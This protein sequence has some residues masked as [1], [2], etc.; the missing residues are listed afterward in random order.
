MCVGGGF[1]FRENFLNRLKEEDSSK[2][3]ESM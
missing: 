1:M 2:Q 3:F